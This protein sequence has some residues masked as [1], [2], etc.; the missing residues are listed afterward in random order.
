MAVYLQARSGIARSGAFKSNYFTT[1]NVVTTVNGTDRSSAILRGSMRVGLALNDEP[2]TA[3]FT[4]K[5]GIFTPVA[6]QLVTISLGSASNT[7]F[8]GQI[9][10]VVH[11]RRR[12]NE[13]PWFDVEC[14]DWQRLF[15]RR[16]AT[17]HYTSLT[18][19]QIARSII[20]AYT[21]GFTHNGVM[22]GLDTID[23]FPL[24]NETPSGALRRLAN[25]IGGGFY[26]DA[27]RDVHLFGSA[28]ESGS[29][30][31]TAPVTLSNSLLTL[32]E[33]QH[34]Y[35]G[36]QQR[37]RV[38]AEGRSTTIPV[39]AIPSGTQGVPVN[40]GDILGADELRLET[41]IVPQFFNTYLVLPTSD[42]ENQPGGVVD[43]AIAVGA[44][45]F[46]VDTTGST[47]WAA[48]AKWAK[49]GEQMITWTSV[50][51]VPPSYTL[52]GVPG[53]GVGAFTAPVE[54]GTPVTAYSGFEVALGATLTDHP[55]DVPVI[56]RMI[57]N[58]TT[59]QTA[60]AAIE[61]GDGIH[62][63]VV[64]DGR[65]DVTGAS[66]L[67]AG[68]LASFAD[69]LLTARWVT[70]DL[71]AR[72]GRSQVINLTVTDALSATLAIIQVE[73]AFPIVNGAPWATC[74][75]AAVKLSGM[76]ERLAESR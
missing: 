27:N 72:P 15:D 21:S 36:T 65:L 30:A 9:S 26:I 4:V 11:R 17:V 62:E 28:G 56:L 75:A 2:D 37:T 66:E 12:G 6:N 19:T 46:V 63:H 18:A 13:S 43:A 59:E 33:F 42:G 20:T 44:T 3:S 7:M 69:E 29:H 52:S 58:D 5:P 60:L 57:E 49:V 16:L 25:L 51:G 38:I 1:M 48:T 41:E 32:K 10:R 24:T 54:V 67:A 64:V 71:N 73:L 61:G 31:G 74:E 14:V 68:E 47:D 40:D 70:T 76:R 45:S 8:G 35:D 23:Y 55:K 50:G 22:A 34:E 39:I 53:S